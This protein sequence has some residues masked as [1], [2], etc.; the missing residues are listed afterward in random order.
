MRP[1]ASSEFSRDNFSGSIEEAVARIHPEDRLVVEEAIRK[2]VAGGPEYMAQYRVVRPDKTICWIDAHGV[3]VRNGPTHVLGIGIDI[4]DLKQTE[5]SLQEAKAELARVT[6]IATMGE[7]TASIAHE[8]NQPLA[9]VVTNGSASLNWLAMR[10][11]DLHEAREAIT[12]A[13]HEAIRA[14]DVI[15]SVRAMVNKDLPKKEDLDRT[16]LSET[17]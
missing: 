9:A 6:R 7:L 4:T 12:R 16:T 17:C 2:V 15:R 3:L 1:T 10:P 14:S 5:Q 13:I 11:P 8:I